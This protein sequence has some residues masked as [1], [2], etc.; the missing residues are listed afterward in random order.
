MVR[1]MDETD[2]EAVADL[3]RMSFSLPWSRDMIKDGFT[4]GFDRF[5]IC[6]QEQEAAGYICFRY[7]EEEGEIERIAVHPRFR[8]MGLGRKLMEA[9]EEY[10][11]GKGVANLTLEVRA[12]N[13]KAIKLYESCGFVKEALRRGYYRKPV[14]DAIIMWRRGI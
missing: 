5:L 2:L 10:V 11:K 9:M 8:G 14:E 6:E 4:K 3:E 13:E 1:W 7:F 12:G